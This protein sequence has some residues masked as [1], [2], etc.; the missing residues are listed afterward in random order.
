MNIIRTKIQLALNALIEERNGTAFQRLAYQCLRSRWP[1]LTSV[2]EQNDLGEDAIT[3]L[4]ETSDGVVRSLACSLTAKWS[5]VSSDANKIAD[6]RSDVQE[7]IFA[8]PKTITRKTQRNWEKCI[9]E[10]FVI[11]LGVKDIRN[12]SIHLVR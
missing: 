5:K 8:T 6:Q 12:Q 3:I 2:A 1:S 10:Q 4:D 11:F 7:L 9:R